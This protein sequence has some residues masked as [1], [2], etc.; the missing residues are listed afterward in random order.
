MDFEQYYKLT[1]SGDNSSFKQHIRLA[2]DAAA[3]EAVKAVDKAFAA[4]DCENLTSLEEY[5]ADRIKEL[6]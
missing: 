3:D 1:Y 2:W 4:N 5:I 6:K